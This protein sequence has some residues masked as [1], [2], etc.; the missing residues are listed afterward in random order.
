M[1]QSI[2]PNQ[3]TGVQRDEV[4]PKGPAS[5]FSVLVREFQDRINRT[6]TIA[7]GSPASIAHS[8]HSGQEPL[9]QVRPHHIDQVFTQFRAICSLAPFV[10]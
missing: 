9:L 8:N 10:R 6:F 4:D 3:T 1:G 5:P 2:E 7:A